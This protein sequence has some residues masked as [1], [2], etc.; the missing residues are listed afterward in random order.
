VTPLVVKHNPKK[1]SSKLM[2]KKS[3]KNVMP[4]YLYNPPYAV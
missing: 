3:S 4:K 2:S 1:S